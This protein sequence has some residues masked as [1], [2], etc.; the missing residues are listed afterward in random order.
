MGR[1]SRINPF[2][3]GTEI[4]LPA[5]V[6]DAFN[7]PLSEGDLVYVET[8]RRDPFRVSKIVPVVDPSVPANLMDITLTCSVK[9]R[10]P[11]NQANQEFVRIM[12]LSEMQR[13]SPQPPVPIV[14]QEP[15]EPSTDADPSL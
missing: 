15:Q 6:R 13:E 9:F 5:I 14:T 2:A 12:E 1:D 4:G 3:R 11:R 7:R 8:G 10:A